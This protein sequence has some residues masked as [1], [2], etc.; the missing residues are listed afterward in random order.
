ME[1]LYLRNLK[2]QFF[3]DDGVKKIMVYFETHMDAAWDLNPIQ[4]PQDGA[5][6]NSDLTLKFKVIENVQGS[7]LTFQVKSWKYIYPVALPDGYKHVTTVYLYHSKGSDGESLGTV[8][9]PT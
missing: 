5:V 7:K 1:N 4:L 8:G 2:A 6:I 3:D 9:D